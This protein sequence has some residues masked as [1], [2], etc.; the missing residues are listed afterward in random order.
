M[1]LKCI[2][3]VGVGLLGGSIGLA[4]K[5]RL[6]NC[7]TVG[8]A[9][10]KTTLA[11]A[12]RLGV[13]DEGYTDLKQ[14]TSRADLVILCTPVGVFKS[15]LAELAPGLGEQ[16][17][18]TDVGSTKRSIVSAAG[19]L[20]RHPQNFVGSHPMAGSEKRGVQHARAD[21]YDGALCIVT[22]TTK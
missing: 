4:V 17:I 6:R 3:I 18:I 20:L 13:I 12:L 14:A 15:I 16:A 2:S 10:R 9:H 1:Q 8:Y 19:E 5:S 7:K 11:E 22:P 21:L